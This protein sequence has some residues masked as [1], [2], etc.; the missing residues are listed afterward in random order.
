MGIDEDEVEN[1]LCR[2]GRDDDGLEALEA[3]GKNE[4]GSRRG[5][6]WHVVVGASGNWELA[7]VVGLEVAFFGSR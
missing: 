1:A 2:V 5:A 3:E 7:P 6:E 4:Q